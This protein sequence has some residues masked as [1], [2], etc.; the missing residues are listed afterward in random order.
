MGK[1]RKDAVEA[2]IEAGEW[3]KAREL[4]R[5]QLKRSPDDHWLLTRLS[6]TY[7]EQGR[8]AEALEYVDKAHAL[9]P[10]CP[11]VLWDYAGTLD[12]LGRKEEAI[13]VYLSLMARGVAGIANDECGEGYEWAAGLLADCVFRVGTCLEDLG[14]TKSAAISYAAYIAMSMTNDIPSI[15]TQEIAMKRLRN[16]PRG[17]GVEE[18]RDAVQ[19]VAAALAQAVGVAGPAGYSVSSC[20]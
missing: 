16:L 19:G 10:T 15:Y 2:L 12:M 3:E 6:T 7:Y 1:A 11:L 13:K 5:K 18:H 9:A 14:A 4:I 17:E 8:Y 20:G